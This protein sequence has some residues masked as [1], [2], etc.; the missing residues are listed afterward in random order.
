MTIVF[1]MPELYKKRMLTKFTKLF[2]TEEAMGF[3]FRSEVDGQF[4][5][6]QQFD[7]LSQKEK[8]RIACETYMHGGVDGVCCTNHA[9]YIDQKLPGRVKIYGFSNQD[10]P[11]SKVARESIHPGGHDF[12]VVDN[13]YIVDS[14]LHLLRGHAKWIFDLQDKDDKKL[15]DDIY[16]PYECW[17]ILENVSS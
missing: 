11:T 9:R 10:N 3:Y 2:G 8:K 6:I 13:R 17:K 12:A 1:G 4:Y 7:S 16:G 15:V 5:S 14:W